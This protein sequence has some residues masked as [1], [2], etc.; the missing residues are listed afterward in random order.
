LPLPPPPE[1]LEPSLQ[2]VAGSEGL[3]QEALRNRPELRA[4]RSQLRGREAA[5][6]LAEREYYPDLGVMTSYNSMWMDPE[7]RWMVG[8]SFNIPLQL[9][10]RRGAVE[11]AEAHKAQLHAQLLSETDAIRVEV[12]VARQRLLEAQQ[13]L[14]L[15][16]D[17]LL[18]AARAQI[19]AARIGYETGS[20]SFQALIDAERSLRSVDLGY[21]VALAELGQRR[22]ELARA[23][24]RILGKTSQGR[25]P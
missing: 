13:V 20:S 2:D 21:Q 1:Q 9:G 3:Q 22:A 25:Q 19:E 10:A 4:S 16:R 12:E 6:E 11:Q 23:M 15:Q 8:I 18:P 5:I 14:R 7:H 17:R 24:G